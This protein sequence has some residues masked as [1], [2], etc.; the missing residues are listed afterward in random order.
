MTPA[1]FTGLRRQAHGHSSRRFVPALETL[2]NRQVPAVSGQSVPLNQNPG[3]LPAAN[4][5]DLASSGLLPPPSGG[6]TNGAAGTNGSGGSAANLSAA[7]ILLDRSLAVP[8][9]ALNI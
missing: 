3:A 5:S 4:Q 8:P 9:T 6:N 2:E 7:Q 1:L